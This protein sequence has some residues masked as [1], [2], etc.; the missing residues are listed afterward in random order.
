MRV[1]FGKGRCGSC[2]AG[3]NLTDESFHNT[4]VSFRDGRML[5]PGRFAVTRNIADRGAFKTPTLREV[6]RTAPYMHDGSESTLEGVVEYYDRG[7]N[8]NPDLDGIL[9]PIG[10]SVNDKR[11]LVGFLRALSGKVREGW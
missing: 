1:F 5:D 9:G 4:G 11:A 7:G 10:L 3:P 2:H 6:V 8:A